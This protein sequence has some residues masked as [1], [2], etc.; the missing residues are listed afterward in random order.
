MLNFNRFLLYDMKVLRQLNLPH[1]TRLS[2]S[3][4]NGDLE[5]ARKLWELLPAGHKIGN[6]EPLFNE[7]V[8]MIFYNFSHFRVF[9]IEYC[10]A[11]CWC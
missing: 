7:L 11:S 9:H 3:D 2:F 5:R 6:P 4:E 1:E 10:K 8:K